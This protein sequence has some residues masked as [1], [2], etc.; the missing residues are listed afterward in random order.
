[1]SY[2]AASAEFTVNSRTVLD[3]SAPNAA[4]L[5]NG[6]VVVVW[7]TSDTTA[8]GSGS[9]IRM[10][11]L[12]ANGVKLGAEQRVNALGAGNQGEP[13]VAALA[14]GN[15][16]VTWQ[17]ADITQDG[18]G[19]AVKAQV[20]APT[21]APLGPE[22][23]VN[24]KTIGDQAGPSVTYLADGGF[25][26]AWHTTDTTQDGAGWAVKAQRFDPSGTKVGGEILVNTAAFGSQN[27]IDLA[28]LADGR[29]VAVWQYGNSASSD[30]RIQLFNPDGTKSGGEIFAYKWDSD[31]TTD[32]SVTALAGGGFAVSFTLG[33]RQPAVQTFDS[34]GA[35]IGSFVYLDEG[36]ASNLTALSTGGFVA[37]WSSY[38]GGAIQAFTATGQKDGAT[39]IAST[40]DYK[41]EGS[42]GV[43][44][45][46][47]RF[48]T[49][50]TAFGDGKD[51]GARIYKPNLAPELGDPVRT[52]SLNENNQFVG[53]TT[54][55]DD[56]SPL[57][58]TYAIVGGTDA[59]KFTIAAATGSLSF[60][61]APDFEAPSDSDGNNVYE[62]IVR[63]SDGELSD[64]QTILV[65]VGN[66]NEAP[67]ITSGG[68]G[69]TATISVEEN[70]TA[71]GTVT[72]TDPENTPIAFTIVGGA[73]AALFNIDKATGLL[74]F[75][76]AP[77][78]EAPADSNGDNVY[79]VVVQAN[80]GARTDVQTLSVTV[81]NVNEGPAF[82]SPS[83]F[84]ASE[85]AL[86]AATVFALDADRDAV[87]YAIVGGDDAA[88][89]TI[90]PAAGVISF[91]AAPDYEAPGDADGDN[92]YRLLVRASDGSL[93]E[94]QAVTISLVNV[95]EAP[96]VTS[97]A[98]FLA[99]ENAAAAGTVAASDV[100]GD[101]LSYSIVGGSDAALFAIDPQTGA[102]SFRA[103]PD[104]EA[105][106]DADGDNRYEVVVRA[107][108]GSL[109]TDQAVT[110]AV[111]NQNE[112]P[113]FTSAAMLATSENG[114]AAGSVAAA[115]PEHD[116]LTYSIAGGSDA[117]LFVI[118]AQTGALSFSAAPDFEAPSDADHDNRYDVVVRASDGSL[119]A[120]QA[121][122]VAVAN[123]NEGPRIT[124]AAA[125]SASEN[126]LAAGTVAGSD[127]DGDALTFSIAGGSDAALFVIDAQTG[128]L[129][130]RAAPDFEAPSDTD[131]DNRYEVVVRASDGS[132]SA[133]QAVT[134]AVA[135]QNEG[136][137]ITSAAAFSASE[138][139]LA[140]GTVAASDVDGD[141]LTYSI[142]G[143]SDAALFAI[144]AR[145]GALSFR[146]APNFEAPGDADGNNRYEVVVRASDGSLFTQQALVV[147]V[148]NV[149]EGQQF[150]SAATLNILE[151]NLS[152]G[153]VVA[154]DTDGDAVTY[155]IVGGADGAR[156]AI[157]SATGAL[158]FRASPDFEAPTDSDANN[159]YEVMVSAGDGTLT[160]SRL[161][162]VKVANAT[163]APAI[164]S[165]GGGDSASF[166]V[167]ENSTA[168]TT[169]VARDP[170]AGALTYSIAG[171]ADAGMFAIDAATGALRFLAAPNFETPG[172]ANG[173]NRYDVVVR[174]SDGSFSDL[175]N[176]VVTVQNVRDGAT[177][178]GTSKADTL[179]GTAAEDTITGLAGNDTLYGNG[180]DDVLNGGDG[181]DKLY[182][183]LG[184]DVLT[185]GANADTFVFTALADSAPGAVDQITDFSRAQN[186]KI[187]LS[188]IDANALVAGDQSFSFIGSN[189]F[190]GA[191]GQLRTYVADAKT[192]VAGDVNGDKVA[193]F[194]IDLGSATVTASDFLL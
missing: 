63:A 97:S 171:G 19:L 29:F 14:N 152:A 175:Q 48:M 34:N 33:G 132:L 184:A 37:S 20:F 39:I 172:D 93:S 92:S 110:V 74:S 7:Q 80:D 120:D 1:M 30:V 167:N 157:D 60:R 115:D 134:V 56:S 183:G 151:N 91:L 178:N 59:A 18:S 15:F 109:S 69:T 36:F 64:T 182:G 54:A 125:F 185:G 40:S 22:F 126:G 99:A 146:N 89:F 45:D 163:E 117:G 180:G 11:L 23:L 67:V 141:A 124:S 116:A 164:L 187:S 112:G 55:I 135:N 90:D 77:D 88:L 118:D 98:T 162:T 76:T 21:G 32:G 28:T 9:G 113:R 156:F 5:G 72:A 43:G 84:A 17:S 61:A 194:I 158:S 12:D 130:F 189:D 2:N 66:V 62:V 170:E 176:L 46:N 133:D 79:Q 138:N 96:V 102:L 155:A 147:T 4:R 16:V 31:G 81:T 160:T 73:D 26:I 107:S 27:N 83:A 148:G 161:V 75:N 149:N 94:T 188:A 82:T 38:S 179:N 139:G 127:V 154:V 57:P 78:R 191:A 106:G 177:L 193:D 168:V 122:T 41:G 108:D 65:T 71:V 153:M 111:A 121:V 119:S 24:T 173:D 114:L 143:G 142:A 104:F 95:N 190:T 144:D 51:I 52:V 47:G 10:Q 174:A 128:A 131:H 166:A 86:A 150:T 13:Q 87:S 49:F 58:L 159:V 42:A 181:N 145:T 68:G 50:W 6:N 101:A 8:D 70:G 25:V 44:L 169:I 103:A 129:S 85:N 105:P 165:G 123:Q 186:D 137:R 100:D 192:F 140:A 35:K 53:L 3:Q 136:P